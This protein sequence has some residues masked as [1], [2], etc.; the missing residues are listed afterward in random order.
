MHVDDPRHQN[1]KVK[2]F[3]Q[4]LPGNRILLLGIRF[5]VMDEYTQYMSDTTIAKY[6]YMVSKHKII[7]SEIKQVPKDAIINLDKQICDTKM[8]I[9]NVVNNIIDVPDGKCIFTMIDVK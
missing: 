9:S 5:G 7:L 4:L 8:T 6:R 3:L 1:S 2:Q